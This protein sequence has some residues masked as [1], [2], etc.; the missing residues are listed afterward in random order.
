[1]WH[2]GSFQGIWIQI[3]DSPC[4]D[5]LLYMYGQCLSTKHKLRRK[6]HDKPP[7]LHRLSEKVLI[8][9]ASCRALSIHNCRVCQ[10]AVNLHLH[11]HHLLEGQPCNSAQWR[12]NHFPSSWRMMSFMKYLIFAPRQSTRQ[13]FTV[14]SRLFPGL[15]PTQIVSLSFSA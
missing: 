6:Q 11:R 5:Q 10:S 8:K 4:I 7:R 15:V 3:D 12:Q 2:Y 13:L 1:M 14:T 9:G